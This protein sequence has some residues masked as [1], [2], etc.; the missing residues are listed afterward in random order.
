VIPPR[1]FPI[2]T[3]S[4]YEI[5]SEGK[6]LIKESGNGNFDRIQINQLRMDLLMVNPTKDYIIVENNAT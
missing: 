4:L 6:E 5:T 1:H 3:L 2:G